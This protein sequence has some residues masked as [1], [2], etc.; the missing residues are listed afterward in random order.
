MSE[1]ATI[2]QT[3][4]NSYLDALADKLP[5]KQVDKIEKIL[6]SM[7]GGKTLLNACKENN[8]SAVTWLLY[9]GKYPELEIAYSKAKQIKLE[10][11]ADKLLTLADEIDADDKNGSNRIKKAQ[12]QINARQWLLA[13]LVANYSEKQ[14]VDVN[15]NIDIG[16]RL[17]KGINRVEKEVN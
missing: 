12:L 11:E 8:L 15:V 4:R 5:E 10:L 14:Q 9:I 1:V 7:M 17:R 3:E 13:R 2:E 6:L 16:E